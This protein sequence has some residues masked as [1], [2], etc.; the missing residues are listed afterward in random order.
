MSRGRKHWEDRIKL[1][2]LGRSVESR[3]GGGTL[4][5]YTGYRLEI[6]PTALVDLSLDQE[7]V[8]FDPS[9]RRT[10]SS[11]SSRSRSPLLP[12]LVGMVGTVSSG[13][14]SSPDAAA[15]VAAT[16]TRARMAMRTPQLRRA[17]PERRGLQA[18]LWDGGDILPCVER[19]GTRGTR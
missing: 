17:Q 9:K 13:V 16:A 14:I 11:Y 15:S 19:G 1:V 5:S 18:L 7:Q 8:T 10:W 6:P 12:I 3:E 4:R 2:I